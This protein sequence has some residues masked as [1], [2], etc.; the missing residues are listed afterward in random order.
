MT[1]DLVNVDRVSA[2]VIKGHEIIRATR[3]FSDDNLI[4]VG[5]FG[6]VFKAQLSDGLIVAIKVLNM[7]SEQASK[8]FDIECQALRMARHRNLVRILSTCSNLDFKALVL[9][10]MHKGSLESLLHS[11]RQAAFG[12]YQEVRHNVGCGNGIG[13]PTLPSL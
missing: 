1:V 3:N 13:I 9:E 11:E 2:D 7:E 8:S 12:V 10:Y 4:G 6:K 5:S